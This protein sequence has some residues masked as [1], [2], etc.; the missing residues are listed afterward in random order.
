MAYGP[1]L[2]QMS[3]DPTPQSGWDLGTILFGNYEARYI[4]QFIKVRTKLLNIYVILEKYTLY[5]EP[6]YLAGSI[7][8]T[9]THHRV[10]E[11]CVNVIS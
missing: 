10:F 11:R 4:K 9:E 5:Q 3:P 6:E 1:K 7:K 2:Q 8:T